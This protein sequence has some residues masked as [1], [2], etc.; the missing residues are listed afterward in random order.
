MRSLQH[1]YFQRLCKNVW[2]KAPFLQG[3]VLAY[4]ASCVDTL[5]PNVYKDPMTVSYAKVL[6]LRQKGRAREC[7]QETTGTSTSA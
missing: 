4:H 3:G 1:P 5:S 6:S 7:A 2:P